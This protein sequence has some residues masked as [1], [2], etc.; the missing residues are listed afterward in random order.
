M[1]I[2]EHILTTAIELFLKEGV[3]RVTMD[4]LAASLG[5]SKRTIYEL[6]K[7][8][9]E[10]L[11][12]CIENHINKQRL[13]IMELSVKSETAVHFYLSVMQIGA[14]NMRSQN[15]QFVN[16]VRIYY[17]KIWASTLCANRDYNIEQSS[18]MLKRGIEEGVFRPNINIPIISKIIIE[19]FTLLSNADIFPY[20]QYPPSEM[21]EQAMITILRGVSSLKGIEIIDEHMNLQK[22]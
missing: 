5:M 10:L 2:K 22:N 12:E 18:L 11:Y 6:F 19:F 7:N 16:D 13:A 14:A 15:P 9:D 1:E 4:Q 17:P 20:H 3:R 8:K 21:F